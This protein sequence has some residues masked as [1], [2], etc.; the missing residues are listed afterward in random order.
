MNGSCRA[1]QRVFHVGRKSNASD[2]RSSIGLTL[3]GG[4]RRMRV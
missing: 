1:P 2:A 4:A 3:R